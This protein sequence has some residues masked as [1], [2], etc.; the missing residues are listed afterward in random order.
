[1]ELQVRTSIDPEH[2]ET[3][4][5]FLSDH[6][7]K[8]MSSSIDCV[9]DTLE[10][11]LY[12]EDRIIGGLLG[13]SLWGTLEVKILSVAEEHRGKGLGKKLMMEAEK[14]AVRRQC[15]YISLNTF[16]F[17]APGFYT[18]LGF[19]VFAEEKDFPLGFSRLY[20]RKTL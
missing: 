12:A 14:E 18:S 11:V 3:L 7:L 10:I 16:S 15:K 8:Y 9:N 20:L 17:Q 13:R 4:K 1:M 6:N 5:Q 19:E 2:E